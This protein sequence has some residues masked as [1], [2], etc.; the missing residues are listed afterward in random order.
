MSIL[1][2]HLIGEV[3]YEH[4]DAEG[5]EDGDH[6]GGG[7]VLPADAEVQPRPGA[8]HQLDVLTEPDNRNVCMN[9]G[10]QVVEKS[11]FTTFG[12][13]RSRQLQCTQTKR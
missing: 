3:P 13:H 7:D 11:I 12:D 8:G 4:L 1:R 2:S 9:C 6:D 5:H 10:F